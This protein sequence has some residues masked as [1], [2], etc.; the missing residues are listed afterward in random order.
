MNYV[1]DGAKSKDPMQNKKDKTKLGIPRSLK[2]K[3]QK[4]VFAQEFFK[5]YQEILEIHI[6]VY[7]F[8]EK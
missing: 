5:K 4:T 8:S 3:F 1:F 7:F 6:F 2:L